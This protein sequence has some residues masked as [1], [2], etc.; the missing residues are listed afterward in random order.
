M[1]SLLTATLLVLMINLFSCTGST[2]E[3]K[4]VIADSSSKAEAVPANQK[5]LMASPA[6]I[7]A[8]KQ[9]P[10]L[11]YH[12]IKDAPVAAYASHG[13][14]VTLAQ[15]KAQMKVLADSGFHSI[16]ND[17]YYNYLAYGTPLPEKPVMI[18]YD[19]TREEH[20]TIAKP[21]MEKYGF[22]GVFF[23]MTISMNR[24]NYMTKQQIKQLSDDGHDVSSHSWDHH[25]VDRLKGEDFTAQFDKPKKQL[26][27]IIGKPV[28]YFAYPFGIWSP[29]AIPEIEK[30]GFKMSY[31]LSTKRDSLEPLQTV[32]RMIV[33]PTW[34]PQGMI[35]VMNSTFR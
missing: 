5:K 9:V 15:F 25:R 6:E 21:E 29:E 33:A 20:F 28:E 14:E 12:R 22:K 30:R 16:T 7:M 35:R 1:K 11:C 27:E 8:R 3:K 2:T 26:E 24:P 18:T 17:Q 23:I 19:D 34:T 4:P 10:V 13:Y 31:I 32:R